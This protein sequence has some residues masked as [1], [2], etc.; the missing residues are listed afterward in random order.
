[1]CDTFV[2]L[3][4]FTND[5]KFYFGKNSDRDPNESHEVVIIPEQ[6]HD[7]E[8]LQCTYIKIPQVTKTNR[9]I[10]SK[11]VW[12][13]GAEI[14]V[15][16][17]GVVIGNEAVFSKIPAGKEPGLI[18]MDYL[19]LG[20]ERGNTAQEALN[21]IT[22]ILEQYGQSGNCGFMHPF[23]YHNSFMIADKTEAWKLETVGKEWIAKKINGFGAISNGYS[24]EDKWD[25]ISEGL[26]P[27]AE[28][29][30]WKKPDQAFNFRESFS[31]WLFTSFSDSKQRQSCSIRKINQTGKN[32]KLSDVFST[33]RA[34]REE[35]AFKPDKGFTGADLCM[36][37]GFG[38]VRVSQTTGSMVV[39]QDNEDLIVWVTG[40][41]APCLSIFKPMVFQQTEN[42]FG[43]K[44]Q[45][46]YDPN[47]YWWQQERI[48]RSII[49]DYQ[50]LSPDYQKERDVLENSFILKMEATENKLDTTQ[51]C[52][53]R[54]LEFQ[55]KWIEIIENE[56][57]K[58]KTNFLHSMFWKK[59]NRLAK[60]PI[61]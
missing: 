22:S 29:K 45:L 6:F 47:S 37:A 35:D 21:V 1:M 3:P 50:R 51:D 52:F 54:S 14:G 59:N 17:H 4:E 36:H 61:E 27:L 10:L 39:V 25:K 33:L 38:P 41:A 8:E 58:N 55:R 60:I 53:E 5:N 11:P 43:S 56:I 46:D 20:L 24:I 23:Y 7:D 42:H 9:M 26:I 34:H 13:W 30:K 57:M 12:I 28:A 32:S 44:P 48:H 15:N 49:K 31:D 16:E 40:S 2:L 18:G 19:R